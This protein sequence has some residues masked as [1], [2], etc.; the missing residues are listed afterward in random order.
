ME[1]VA[2]S[3][4][5]ETGCGKRKIQIYGDSGNEYPRGSLPAGEYDTSF[6]CSGEDTNNSLPQFQVPF[7][8]NGNSTE[9]ESGSPSQK[10]SNT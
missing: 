8:E 6:R 4:Q 3:A 2:Y 9:Y 1:K 5:T 10:T 7:Q